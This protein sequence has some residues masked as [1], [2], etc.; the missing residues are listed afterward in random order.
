[1]YR[2]RLERAKKQGNIDTPRTKTRKLMGTKNNKMIARKL[3]FGEVLHT[4]L[5][6]NFKRIKCHRKKFA[7]AS[8]ILGDR[9]ILKKYKVTT[10]LVSSLLPTHSTRYLS[11]TNNSMKKTKQRAIHNKIKRDVQEFL[12]DDEHSRLAPGKRDTKT[13][14]KEKKQK[15][16]LNDTLYNLHKK[17]NAKVTYSISYAQF[18]RYRPFWVVYQ[19]TAETRDTCQCKVCVNT[20][21]LVRGMYNS[22]MINFQNGKAILQHLTCDGR[23]DCFLGKCKECQNKVVPYNEFNGN[24]HVKYYEWCTQEETYK[25]KNGQMKTSKHTVRLQR[26]CNA[27]KLVAVLDDHIEKYKRHQA[28]IQNQYTALKYLK[29]TLKADEI[30][31]HM[32]FSENYSMKYASEIQ[33]FHFG[34]SR[35]QVTLHTSALT[36]KNNVYEELKTKSFCTFAKS[37]KHDPTAILCHLEPIFEYIRELKPHLKIINF[38]SDGPAT[39]YRNQLMFYIFANIIDGYFP[40]LIYSTWNSQTAHNLSARCVENFLN[41]TITL[42]K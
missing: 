27:Y 40:S 19:C 14:Q 3:V 20:D 5:K 34:G 22:K 32:D 42:L 6:S 31:L 1:M 2:K 23:L 35:Q 9:K 16:Y 39:Q 21:F 4:Q 18:C 7:Y 37:L 36:Y 10:D 24:M 29:V 12:E 25:D 28:I 26:T 30:V 33:S 15:R 13:L 17:F 41:F 38:L 11:K 8:A